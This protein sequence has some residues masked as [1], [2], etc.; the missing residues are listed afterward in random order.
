MGRH[1]ILICALFLLP[2]SAFAVQRQVF[3]TG[4]EVAD[5]PAGSIS[6]S[7]G[8][9][10]NVEAEAE[11]RDD[12]VMIYLTYDDGDADTSGV[13]TLPS[14]AGPVREFSLPDGLDTV[15]LNL[16][17]GAVTPYQPIGQAPVRTGTGLEPGWPGQ[18]WSVSLGGGWIDMP[19]SEI[20]TAGVQVSPDEGTPSLELDDSVDTTLAGFSLNMPIGNRFGL[21]LGYMEWDGDK[22]DSAEFE[23]GT[24]IDW[25]VLYPFD[26]AGN[27]GLVAGDTGIFSRTGFDVEG[28]KYSLTAAWPCD[29]DLGRWSLQ[30]FVG[31]AWVDEERRYDQLDSFPGIPGVSVRQRI[32]VDVE[33]WDIFAGANL[34]RPL[35][36]HWSLRITAGL[37]YQDMDADATIVQSTDLFGTVTDRAFDASASDSSVSYIAG[38]GAVLNIRNQ[39]GIDFG[40]NYLG[41]GTYADVQNTSNGDAILDGET[42]DVDGDSGD[43]Y[44]FTIR[45]T[46]QFGG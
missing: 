23:P 7:G 21:S 16:S 11:Q 1:T 39:L 38:I 14:G 34:V 22:S 27:T 32:D 20:S 25:G 5:V 15:A 24:G 41:N 31:A 19:A 3:V 42:F 29:R 28:S 44:G 26:D 17:S 12:G 13:L 43:S 18:G 9:V 2:V 37:N 4:A 8:N 40:Y 6:F 30:P 36:D 33:M 10:S 35:N 45:A 46:Y